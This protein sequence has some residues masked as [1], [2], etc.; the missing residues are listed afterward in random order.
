MDC[1]DTYGCKS[2]YGLECVKG[3]TLARSGEIAGEFQL[4]E[5][6][7]TGVTRG[8]QARA[9]T[10]TK[11]ITTTTKPTTTKTTTKATTTGPSTTTKTTTT[12]TK[13]TTST[14]TTTTTTTVITVGYCDC[15]NLTYKYKH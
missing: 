13:T 15:V 10:T 1:F 12:T 7:T 14:T 3:Q 5:E 2:F 4:H 9:L 11:K 6:F 8:K